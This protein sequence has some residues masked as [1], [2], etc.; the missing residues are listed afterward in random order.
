MAG[1]PFSVLGCYSLSEY[2]GSSTPLPPTS[3]A[4]TSTTDV[5]KESTQNLGNVIKEKITPQLAIENTPTSH[6]PIEIIEGV[7]NDVELEKTLNK[8]KDIT[9]FLKILP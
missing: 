7:I 6:R 5:I 3:S 4:P 9:G 8:M 2:I 1:R